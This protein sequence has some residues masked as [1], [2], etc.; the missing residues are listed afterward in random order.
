MAYGHNTGV[1]QVLVRVVREGPAIVSLHLSVHSSAAP[2]ERAAQAASGRPGPAP[3]SGGGRAS[4]RAA[5]AG[6]DR[7]RR[8]S[9]AEAVGTGARARMGRGKILAAAFGSVV[10]EAARRSSAYASVDKLEFNPVRIFLGE[11]DWM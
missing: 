6:G 1:Q 9:D 7:A 8:C 10:Q 2:S 4:A 11:R 5:A 3:A